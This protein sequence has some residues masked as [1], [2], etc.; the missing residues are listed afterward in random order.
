MAAAN[1]CL[2]G[3]CL[4]VG[5]SNVD[6]ACEALLQCGVVVDPDA[7][8]FAAAEGDEAF[9]QVFAALRGTRLPSGRRASLVH[10]IVDSRSTRASVNRA[11][12][13]APCRAWPARACS[14]PQTLA[15]LLTQSMNAGVQP[16]VLVDTASSLPPRLQSCISLAVFSPSADN[17]PLFIDFNSRDGTRLINPW[18]YSGSDSDSES[19]SESGEG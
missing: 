12:R 7:A 18:T 13:R 6:A 2:E 10:L 15:Y 3:P 8:V 9:Q 14:W 17:G 16:F 11:L 4:L 1:I 5:F 19:E